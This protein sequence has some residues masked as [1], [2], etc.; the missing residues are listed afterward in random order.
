[1]EMKE[2]DKETAYLQAENYLEEGKISAAMFYYALAG[3]YK[4]ARLQYTTLYGH[5]NS[6]IV[7]GALILSIEPGGKVVWAYNQGEDFLYDIAYEENDIHLMAVT[8]AGEN[9]ALAITTSGEAILIYCN[10]NPLEEYPDDSR[11]SNKLAEAKLD[12]RSIFSSSEN[13]LA[14]SS[15]GDYH[16]GVT[17]GQKIV[18]LVEEEKDSYKEDI[19]DIL[20]KTADWQNIISVSASEYFTIVLKADGTLVA[21]GNN[22][23]KQC[24]IKSWKNIVA[25][26]TGNLHTVGLRED[27]TVVATGYKN[28][29]ACDV[30]DWEDIVAIYAHNDYTIGIKRDGTILTAG[31][32]LYDGEVSCWENLTAISNSRDDM[33]TLLLGVRKDGTVL[34]TTDYGP[35]LT[36]WKVQVWEEN[37]TIVDEDEPEYPFGG[38][39]DHDYANEEFRP[40]YNNETE[41][42]LIGRSGVQ[43]D[44]SSYVVKQGDWIYYS[45]SESGNGIYKM[46]ID[47]SQDQ[48]VKLTS[49]SPSSS[50]RG[51]NVV[52]DWIYYMQIDPATNDSFSCDLVRLRT[53]GL[54][55]EVLLKEVYNF[56]VIGDAIYYTHEERL[57]SSTTKKSVW[58]V[59]VSGGESEYLFDGSLYGANK[60]QLQILNEDDSSYLYDLNNHSKTMINYP[61]GFNNFYGQLSES[62][63]TLFAFVRKGY[64]DIGYNYYIDDI[65]EWIGIQINKAFKDV[66]IYD[67]WAYYSKDNEG[68][69]KRNLRTGEA[70][71]K[72]CN[73]YDIYNLIVPGDGWIYYKPMKN[74]RA[75]RI[76]TDGTGWEEIGYMEPEVQPADES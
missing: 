53:D 34:K 55:K 67:G 26:D 10:F 41:I 37:R 36:D 70:E 72:V 33:G 24:D 4:D 32:F 14:V 49:D 8:H 20:E 28:S 38:E 7:A 18:M 50:G 19:K 29:G 17:S 58:K 52:G 22:S 30:T 11:L 51:I 6:S 68:M 27:G 71:Q 73:D 16:L 35:D 47:G 63:N 1:M 5:L 56:I 57:D 62:P 74:Q 2:S 21:A 66:A 45:I 12:E 3:D 48:I 61:E 42:N 43:F 44:R 60:H 46:P 40:D 69:F 54:I 75:C 23:S 65:E 13:I 15:A 9:E 39:D 76:R 25:I 64:F 59:S 31:Y